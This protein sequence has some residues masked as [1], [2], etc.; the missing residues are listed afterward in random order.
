MGAWELA[1]RFSYV[2]LNDGNI[3][4]GKERNC[5][6]G[7]NWY[8]RGKQRSMINYIR[9]GVEDRMNPFVDDVSADIFQIRFQVGL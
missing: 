3:R 8:T 6:I 4:G 5:T 2:D 7:I 9:G 1:L